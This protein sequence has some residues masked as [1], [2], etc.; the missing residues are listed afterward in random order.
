MYE[1][2]FEVWPK[3]GD[4][5]LVAGAFWIYPYFDVIRTYRK[6]GMRF[7]VFIHDTRTTTLAGAE[8]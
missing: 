4:I 1:T 6:K 2:R 5:F 7:G 8:P 3:Q